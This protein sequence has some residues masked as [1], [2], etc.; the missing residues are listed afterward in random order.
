MSQQKNTV[1]SPIEAQ[2]RYVGNSDVNGLHLF[3]PNLLTIYGLGSYYIGFPLYIVC[4]L[5]GGR[6]L[7]A[8]SLMD[9]L[10]L[11]GILMAA[12]G[13]LMDALDGW[14]SRVLRRKIKEP[15][16]EWGDLQGDVSA[17]VTENG[18]TERKV[19][20]HGIRSYGAK[21]WLEI[22]YPGGTHL[23]QALDPHADKLKMDPSLILY[24]FLGILNPWLVAIFIPPEVIGSLMRRPWPLLEKWS[25]GQSA[26]P[27]GKVKVYFVWVI[28]AAGVPF[29]EGW[30]ESVLVA[31]VTMAVA[32]PFAYASV[33]SRWGKKK[34]E[35][36]DD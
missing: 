27:Y 4:N 28:L 15:P 2:L 26:T 14:M 20:G 24:I 9:I 33:V 13:G 18:V 5:A 10:A 35:V 8:D 30:T 21:L 34:L 11:I 29:L 36:S 22:T 31:N 7:S 16:D 3:A 32:I 6:L 1:L 25:H 12:L 23:G 19:I 17:T